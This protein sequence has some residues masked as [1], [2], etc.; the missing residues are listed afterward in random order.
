MG[1]MQN[2]H[3]GFIFENKHAVL[4]SFK[5][6]G[7]FGLFAFI[8]SLAREIIKDLED[9]KGDKATGGST[10]PIVWG[11]RASKLN[12]FFLMVITAILLSFVVYNTIR[13]QRVILSLN[14]IYIVAGLIVP[15][16]TLSMYTLS[17][18]N[19]YQFSRASHALKFIMLVGLGYS[20]I[21]Y[22]A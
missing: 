15:L 8:T 12:A 21:Y 18:G 22:Y 4:S 7:I 20:F 14:N 11:I 19:T 6:V 3:P 13:V 2:I 1:L 10:M 16:V 17:A 9:Y 5:I